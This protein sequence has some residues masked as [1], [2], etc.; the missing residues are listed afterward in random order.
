MT[1]VT[2][3]TLNAETADA[4]VAALGLIFEDAPW[5]AAAAAAQRPFPTLAALHEAMMAALATAPPTEQLAFL[6][7]HPELA[8]QAA[9]A[10]ALGQASTAEQHGLRLAE[11]G[12][13]SAEITR[14][15]QEYGARF[16]YPFILC[17][18]RYSRPSVLAAFRRRVTQTPEHEWSAAMQ[19]IGFITRLRLV[20]RVEGPGAPPVHGRITTHVLD[21][22]RG[23]PAPGVKIMLRDAAGSILAETESNADGRTDQPLYAGAPL[24]IGPYEL[25]FHLGQLFEAFGGGFFITVPIHFSVTEPEGHHH[26]PLVVSPGAYSTYRGS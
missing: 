6:R 5:V 17:V 14:L 2:L 23:R 13:D 16:G 21:T 11:P 25:T 26:V 12:V 8:G 3:D 7:G 24:R 15:N 4:F 18:R 20:D 19:E 9:Q 1:K 22:A 10:A